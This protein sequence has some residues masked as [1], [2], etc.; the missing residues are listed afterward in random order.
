MAKATATRTVKRGRGG[1]AKPLKAPADKRGQGRNTTGLVP[2]KKGHRQTGRQKGV[3][4]KFTTKLKDAILA[5]AEASGRNGKGKDGAIGYLV[6]LSRT[7]PAVFG[8]LL[9]KVMPMQID[10][11]DTSTKTYTPQEA[12]DRLK[13]RGLPVPPSLTTLAEQMGRAVVER[14]EEDYDAEL[15]GD[16]ENDSEEGSEDAA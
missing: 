1:Q 12:I 5:A 3:P 15:D 2:F 11:K 13:E 16:G 4:N 14:Q 10:V 9:E 8:R 6:W 7:E